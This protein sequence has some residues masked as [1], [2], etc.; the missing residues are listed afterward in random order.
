MSVVVAGAETV[1]LPVGGQWLLCVDVYDLDGCPVADDTVTVTVTDP[2]AATTTP[3]VETVRS[4]RYRAVVYPAAAGR[5]SAAIATGYGA[6][7]AVAYVSAPV[8][9]PD[10]DALAGYLSPTSVDTGRLAEVLDVEIRA[11]RDVCWLPAQY[12]VSLREAVL[13]RCACNLA[14]QGIPLAVQ[15]GD[16][17]SGGTVMPPTYDPEVRRLEGPYRKLVTG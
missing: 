12:T 9:L 15:Q 3:A 4:G 11:Q 1:D 2:A 14:R 8:E 17:E 16:A 5:W 10:T 7:A 6:A 13:R